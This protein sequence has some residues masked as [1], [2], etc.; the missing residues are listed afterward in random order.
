MLGEIL[1]SPFHFYVKHFHLLPI[2]LGYFTTHITLFIS[3]KIS[4]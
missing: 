2:F 4:Y 1:V 3:D